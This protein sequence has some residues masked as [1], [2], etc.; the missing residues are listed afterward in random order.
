MKLYMISIGGK[1]PAG[2]MEVHDV[3]LASTLCM[4]SDIL[5]S[6]KRLTRL[7]FDCSK[8]LFLLLPSMLN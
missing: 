8:S 4:I 5:L 1:L 7:L 3:V 2:N 6:L